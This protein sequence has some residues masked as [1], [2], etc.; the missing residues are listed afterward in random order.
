MGYLAGTIIAV[1]SGLIL[2]AVTYVQHELHGPASRPAPVYA[3]SAAR[4]VRRARR[5]RRV[6]PGDS[7]VCGGAVGRTG[8]A[9]ARFGDLLGCTGCTRSWTMDGHRIIRQRPRTVPGGGQD[10]RREAAVP[11]VVDVRTAGQ[12][13]G[14]R[15]WRR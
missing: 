6:A 5:A 1:V 14:E 11:A 7:C 4:R 2:V 8:R 15:P 3:A 12:E 13:E 9:S 10:G